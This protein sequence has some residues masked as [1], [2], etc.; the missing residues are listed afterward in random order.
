MTDTTGKSIFS[1]LDTSLMRSTQLP[2]TTVRDVASKPV[3]QQT[4]KEVN[5]FASK[6]ADQ[7]VSKETNQQTSKEVKKQTN[8]PANQQTSKSLK[9]FSSY[10]TE[11]SLK[12]M[13]RNAFETDRKDYEVLQEAVDQYLQR[14]K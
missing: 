14:V 13:K 12:G 7:Q 3:N 4:S 2:P 10:L 1:R 5:Q 9:K 8:L 11:E 6:P